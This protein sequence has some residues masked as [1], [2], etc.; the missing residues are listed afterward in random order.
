MDDDR[1]MYFYKDILQIDD[2]VHGFG[3]VTKLETTKTRNYDSE[4]SKL[5]NHDVK[6][7]NSMTKSRKN[8]SENSILRNRE[9]RNP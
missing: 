5:I 9:K 6:S 1:R 4:K 3:T 8:N 2:Y 7:R